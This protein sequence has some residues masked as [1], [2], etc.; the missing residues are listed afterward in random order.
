M[1][2]DPDGTVVVYSGDDPRFEYVYTFVASKKMAKGS[3]G[4]AKAHNLSLLED[5]DLYVARFTGDGTADGD[6]DGTGT[7]LPLVVDGTSKVPG[8]SVAEV[9]LFT[10]TAADKVGATK[11]D[12]PEDVEVNPV[13]NR[14]YMAMTNNTKRVPTQIDEANPRANNKHGHIV[15]LKPGR[16]GHQDSG[17]TWKLVLIAGDPTDPSTSFDGYDKS[18]VTSI[19]CPDNVAF[20]KAGNLWISTDGQPGTLNHCDGLFLMPVAGPEKGKLRQFLSVPVGAETCG[21]WI[22]EDEKSVLVR[23][24]TRAR[25]TGPPPTTS[26]PPSPTPGSSSPA[27]RWCR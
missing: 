13:N 7:W 2:V 9:L 14:L 27:P 25:S 21:P 4:R 6:H 5:G 16:R 8:M 26:P 17:F 3:S 10:R 24:S 1:T 18:A 19:S 12:R 15:E 22:M 11:M 23:C 20:D